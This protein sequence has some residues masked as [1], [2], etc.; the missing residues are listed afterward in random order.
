[1]PEVASYLAANAGVSAQGAWR[2]R[3]SD[4]ILALLAEEAEAGRPGCSAMAR[5]SPGRAAMLHRRAAAYRRRR[6]PPRARE[7]DLK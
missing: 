5:L 3:L 6:T 2:L 7:N 1:S 4:R